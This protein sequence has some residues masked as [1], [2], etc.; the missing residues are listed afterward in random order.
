MIPVETLLI[1]S[2]TILCACCASFICDS[3]GL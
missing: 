1:V 3:V 2:L